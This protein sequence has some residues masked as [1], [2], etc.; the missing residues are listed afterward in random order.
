MDYVLQPTF[1][2]IT[3]LKRANLYQCVCGFINPTGTRIGDVSIAH[4]G[5]QSASLS[6]TIL[7][8]DKSN[9]HTNGSRGT[10]MFATRMHS[11]GVRRNLCVFLAQKTCAE[12]FRTICG[13]HIP[14]ECDR[15]RR[16]LYL[17][18]ATA[19]TTPTRFLEQNLRPTKAACF[20]CMWCA[21]LHAV[22]VAA[23]AVASNGFSST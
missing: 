11:F 17:A 4:T 12:M 13:A 2:W 23:A 19:T 20:R 18:H 22:A 7:Q 14:Y 8:S 10:N 1:C 15:R 9:T 5:T 21:Y 16:V 3:G 6:L